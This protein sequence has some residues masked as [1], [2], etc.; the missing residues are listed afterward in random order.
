MQFVAIGKKHFVL[1]FKAI[2]AKVYILEE[3]EKIRETL[4]E[5]IKEKVGIILVPDDILPYIEDILEKM[6]DTPLPC[7][8]GVATV[9][10]SKF[11]KERITSF[12][13]KA[14]GVDI[15]KKE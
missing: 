10:G 6:A 5:V 12:V 1:P 11:S 15:I 3:Q 2:G 13:K 9:E 4:I 14:I 8:V 7:V